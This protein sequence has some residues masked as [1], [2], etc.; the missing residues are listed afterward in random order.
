ME[1]L[2]FLCFSFLPSFIK[3][4][5]L[6][7]SAI[8]EILAQSIPTALSHLYC[9]EAD[10]ITN[11]TISWY[12]V[13]TGQL[14]IIIYQNMVAFVM[15]S[16]STQRRC[17]SAVGKDY[18]SISQMA[19]LQSSIASVND[20]RKEIQSKRVPNMRQQVQKLVFG[21][22]AD[23]IDQKNQLK[24]VTQCTKCEKS[25]VE[26]EKKVTISWKKIRPGQCQPYM[27]E[28][29]EPSDFAN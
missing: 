15:K 9:V 5:L 21:T 13:V 10:F 17:D 20:R 29:F 7:I 23:M 2:F 16:A 19:L 4:I 11:T 26:V 22:L 18:D 28:K 8:C 1:T 3:V 25:A 14:V 27:Q 12:I 6:Y 24:Q